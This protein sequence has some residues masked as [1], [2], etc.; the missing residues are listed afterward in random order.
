MAESAER[1]GF[2]G[3]IGAR[4]Y[5]GE[6]VP[7]H[8][9]NLV[10]RDYAGRHDLS[11]KLSAVE[12]AMLDC[13]MMIEDLLA[14]LPNLEG[15]IFYSLFMLPPRAESRQRIFGKTLDSGGI[16]HF[17]VEELRLGGRDDIQQLEDIWRLR[18]LM[19]KAASPAAM[20]AL[21]LSS[22]EKEG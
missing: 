2:R 6:R 14:D 18:L 15:I 11:F 16:L 12:Y 10:V 8:V 17:A 9:Q 5:L 7:Q 20:S 22:A 21:G 19:P 3:Y 4:P 13:F 1:Q